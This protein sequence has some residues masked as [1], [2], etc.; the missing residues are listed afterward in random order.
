[1]PGEAI[2]P[3]LGSDSASLH[4]AWGTG[5]PCCYGGQAAVYRLALDCGATRKTSRQ[6]TLGGVAWAE[7]GA[8]GGARSPR[9]RQGLRRSLNFGAMGF[10][11]S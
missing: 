5:K 10:T 9:T 11:S 8:K 7:D 2:L 3:A 6:P 1:M 4:P